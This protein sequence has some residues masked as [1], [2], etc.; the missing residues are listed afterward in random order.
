M[1]I[2]AAAGSAIYRGAL[3]TQQYGADLVTST[4][5]RL[6]SGRKGLTPVI[7]TDY[8]VQKSILTAAYSDPNKGNKLDIMV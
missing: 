4:I 6:N 7:N 8:A 1:S 2:E 3:E 5:D